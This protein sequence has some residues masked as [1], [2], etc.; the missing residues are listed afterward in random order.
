MPKIYL[1]LKH[2]VAA[3]ARHNFGGGPN[4]PG[5]ELNVGNISP[6][7]GKLLAMAQCNVNDKVI[8]QC[9]CERQWQR[10]MR[11]EHIARNADVF[12]AEVRDETQFLTEAE[13]C[14]LAGVEPLRGE[15]MGEFVCIGIPG[16]IMQPNGTPSSTNS[17]WQ[18][19]RD[20]AARLIDVIDAAFDA[21]LFDYIDQS[22]REA[23]RQ[24]LD[25]F[26][27]D[28]LEAFMTRNDIRNCT[29]DREK[30]CLWRR[31]YRYLEANKDQGND[32]DDMDEEFYTGKERQREAVKRPSQKKH[33]M[34]IDTGE[35]F[36]SILEAATKNDVG[37]SALRMAI[38]RG[39]RCAGKEFVLR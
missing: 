34:C 20:T 10:M 9:Y 19:M 39:T 25:R 32:T 33:I 31:Y 4:D 30:R 2:F 5:R 28:A 26:T 17:Q 6:E 16:E 1:R 35:I 12:M 38:K 13:V 15:S 29:D 14:K 23:K 37:Y 22:V 11:G 24:N 36:D 8:P 21:A 27:S 3:W 7:A 18:L